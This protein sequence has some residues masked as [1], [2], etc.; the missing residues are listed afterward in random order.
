[1]KFWKTS[2]SQIRRHWICLKKNLCPYGFSPFVNYTN[3]R[4]FEVFEDLTYHVRDD[5]PKIEQSLKKE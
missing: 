2:S 1:M 3:L 5:F 4:S